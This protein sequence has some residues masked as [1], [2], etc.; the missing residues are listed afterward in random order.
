MFSKLYDL[1]PFYR[2]SAAFA[3]A[4]P[5]KLRT[6]RVHKDRPNLLAVTVCTINPASL[7][8][9]VPPIAQKLHQPHPPAASPCG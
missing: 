9:H 4:G 7:Q 8:A 5:C 1:P 6:G 2:K 3:M